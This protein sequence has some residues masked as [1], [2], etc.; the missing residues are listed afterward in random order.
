MET[1]TEYLKALI[2]Q[3]MPITQDKAIKVREL[4]DRI[5]INPRVVRQ[6]VQELRLEGH[7][8]C[9]TTSDGYWVTNNPDDIDKTLR[10]LEAQE[11]TIRATINSLTQA[12]FMIKVV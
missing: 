8:I 4:A 12:K 2:I 7:P 10:Q 3:Y 11:S 9:S 5:G 1:N 6:L